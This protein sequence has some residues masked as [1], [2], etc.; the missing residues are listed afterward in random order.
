[1]GKCST[2]G[3]ICCKAGS[4]CGSSAEGFTDCNGTPHHKE[5]Y[6][7]IKNENGENV[8]QYIGCTGDPPGG[9]RRKSRR[10]RSKS[11]KGRKSRRH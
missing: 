1:M 2:D 3:K 7:S 5:K 9:G 10:R 8:S 11:R 4:F 6:G